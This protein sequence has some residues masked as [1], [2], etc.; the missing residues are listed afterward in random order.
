MKMGDKL[1]LVT[2]SDLPAG[3]QAVQAA[4]ALREFVAAFPELD[5]LWYE[6]SNYLALLAA[7]DEWSLHRIVQKARRRGVP[8]VC[9]REP[10]LEDAVTA[11]AL[12]PAGK[13]LVRSLPL[14]LAV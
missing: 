12:A 13:N 11:V 6:R 5:K 1:Y 3:Q 2:R 7:P 10:D 14:A 4:H 9:F 8:V